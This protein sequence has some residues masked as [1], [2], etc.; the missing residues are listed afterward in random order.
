MSVQE[1]SEAVNQTAPSESGPGISSGSAGN[2]D[3]IR[4]ILFGPQLREYGQR[5][6]RIEERLSQETEELKAEVRRR[7]ETLEGYA[8]QEVKDW[9]ERLR[10]ERDERAAAA[11]R[12]SQTLANSVKLLENRLTESDERTSNAL[13]ELRQQT[14]DRIKSLV[15]DFTTEINTMQS[16]Q[17]R[18][19]EELRGSSIDRFA[20]ASL[21]TELAVRVRGDLAV[22]GLREPDGHP[23]P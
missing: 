1:A 14:F 20:F 22:P 13:R 15:D 23:K 6:T 3:R 7:L 18:H 10:T 19:L 17:K 8:R 12:L 11:D 21:L 9:N 16:C 2:V 4:E 5:L